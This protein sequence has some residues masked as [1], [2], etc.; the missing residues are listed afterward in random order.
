MKKNILFAVVALMGLFGFVS[1][2]VSDNPS[3]GGQTTEDLGILEVL[4]DICDWTRLM[5]QT[6]AISV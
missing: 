1:C 5:L 3:E 6:S 4:N 2:E